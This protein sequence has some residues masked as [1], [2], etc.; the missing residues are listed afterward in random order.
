MTRFSL[1]THPFL[2]AI[3]TAYVLL[4]LL[5]SLTTPFFEK[6]D[7]LY[8]VAYIVH[9]ADGK[10]FPAFDPHNPA[11]QE[12]TQPP[13]YY[14]AGA[15]LIAGIDTGDMAS[16]TR[17]NPYYRPIWDGVA[18]D[19]RNRY[20]HTVDEVTP[21]SGAAL[22]VRLLRC[23][24]IAIGGAAVVCTYFV[25]IALFSERR[26]LAAAAMALCAFNPRFLYV[27]GTVNNDVMVAATCALTGLLALRAM[28]APQL[29]LRHAVAL[30]VALGAA[31]L[32][33]VSA[34]VMLPVVA[35]ALIYAAHKAAGSGRGV[36][37]LVLRWGGVILVC[38]AALS[39]W[40][41]ARNAI[42]LGGD[43]AGT[44]VHVTKWG[45]RTEALT[46]DDLRLEVQGLEESYW[47]VFG[48]NSIP[49]A[50]WINLILFGVDRLAL[51]GAIVL[52]VKQWTRWRLDRETRLALLALA[53]WAAGSLASV[54]YWIALMR[55]VNLGRLL[56]PAIAALSTGIALGLCQF[57]P[58][59]WQPAVVGIASVGLL[60][61]AVASPFVYIRPNYAPPPI[62]DESEVGPLTE[63]LDASFQGQVTLLGYEAHDEVTW[64]GDRVS[65]TLYYQ[66]MVP[67][68]IDYTV[69]VHLVDQWGNILVQQ[70]TY[71][72]MGRYPTTSWQPGQ[73]I[74][75]TFYLTMPEW[76]PVPG[77]GTFEVGFY[78]RATGVR[79]LVVDADGQVTGDSIWFYSLPFRAPPEGG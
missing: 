24:S 18:G 69:F 27:S 58:R 50:R 59:R 41:F 51:V 28:R 32:S 60:A 54:C 48:L 6:T 63:R 38:A 43:L 46:L 3:L 71:T 68:G 67:F 11:R 23:L 36:L 76:T 77:T 29:R 40:W 17:L 34:V 22:A 13:L 19:N 74:A 35:C 78:D 47:A 5:Y 14:L 56:Y 52:A 16:L 62:L 65:I 55:G 45:R 10:G 57:A 1:K 7:E 44:T 15:L 70:D 66:A 75:D 49:I 64:P 42:L 39:G 8:H 20:M 2:Y 25:S 31:L 61:L 37:P 26:W 33:K 73:I 79:L 72:G 12:A 4:A 9:L 21:R 53:V 30:G